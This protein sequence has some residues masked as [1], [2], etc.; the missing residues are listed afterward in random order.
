MMY[1]AILRE[2]FVENTNE[3]DHVTSE[4]A[5]LLKQLHMILNEA[6]SMYYLR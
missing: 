5:I 3:F 2:V 1:S 4:R 6:L